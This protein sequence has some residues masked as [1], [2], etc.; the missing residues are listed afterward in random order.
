MAKVA[1]VSAKRGETQL[2]VAL[3][4]AREQRRIQLRAARLLVQV[5]HPLWSP[6]EDSRILK[7]KSQGIHFTAISDDLGRSRIAVEQRWH[8]LRAVPQVQQLLIDFG[9]SEKRWPDALMDVLGAGG[10]G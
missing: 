3:A 5:V 4:E 2:Q 10:A 6:D 9:T 1:T 8:R 7:M